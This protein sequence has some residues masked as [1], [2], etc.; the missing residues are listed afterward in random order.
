MH[1]FSRSTAWQGKLRRV[2]TVGSRGRAAVTFVAAAWT[3][4][5]QGC[6]ESLPLRQGVAPETG[7]VEL[8]LNDQGRAA[9]SERLGTMVDK[10][11]GQML[12]QRADAYTISVV[13]ISQLNGGSALWNGEEVTLLKAH[14]AGF[15]V[16]QMSKPR[17]IALAAAAAALVLAV[18]SKDLIGGGSDDKVQSPPM[19]EPSLQRRI[20]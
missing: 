14:T 20:P 17:T 3:V 9:L 5:L 11:E 8:I 6:Y 15:Q 19:T 10:V 16:R 2:R 7:R 12:S 1:E 18:F 4:A 13:R